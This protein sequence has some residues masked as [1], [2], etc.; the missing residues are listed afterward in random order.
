MR[1]KDTHDLT[2]YFVRCKLERTER[3]W[4][5]LRAKNIVGRLLFKRICS[6]RRM[7]RFAELYFEGKKADWELIP[8][9]PVGDVLDVACD[10]PLDGFWIGRLPGIRRVVLTDLKKPVGLPL[11]KIDFVKANATRLPFP[12]NSFD[13]VTSFSSVEHCMNRKA[14]AQWIQEMTRVTKPNG[15][16]AITVDNAQSILNGFPFFLVIPNKQMLPLSWSTLERMILSSGPIRIEKKASSRL[17]QYTS[18]LRPWAESLPS[19]WLEKA[20]TPVN[21]K[22]PILDARIG[23]QYRKLAA[24]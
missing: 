3:K 15:I 24:Q 13:L 8:E 12:D 17:Y 11:P 6:R 19:Y 18:W 7:E 14:Q 1:I 10:I 9:N 20:L 16:V 22:V 23:I 5:R 21:G 4:S 2:E